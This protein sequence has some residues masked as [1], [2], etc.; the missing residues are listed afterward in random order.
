MARA[1]RDTGWS[2][3]RSARQH[4]GTRRSPEIRPLK[5]QLDYTTHTERL[6]PASTSSHSTRWAGREKAGQRKIKVC[7]NLF[8]KRPVQLWVRLSHVRDGDQLIEAARCSLSFW[9]GLIRL[10]V[11]AQPGTLTLTQTHTGTRKK[12]ETAR[13][14]EREFSSSPT[15]SSLFRFSPQLLII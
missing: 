15:L 12:N 1:Q 2:C 3:S 6:V 13:E 11:H 4:G 5:L 10:D 9:T 7:L 14:R 8:F